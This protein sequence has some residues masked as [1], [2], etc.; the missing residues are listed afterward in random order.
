MAE[1]GNDGKETTADVLVDRLLDWRVSV[2]FGLPGDGINGIMEALRKRRERIRFVQVRHEEAA[3][4]MASGYAKFTGELGVCLAT[5]GPGAIHLLNGLYDAKL[6]GAPVL[7]LT[8]QIYHDLLGTR[9]QQEVDLLRLFDDVALYNHEITGP[10]HV[11]SLVDSACRS[12]LSGRGVAHLTCS[13]DI[14]EHEVK[15]ARK[16]KQ[17]VPGHTSP[18]WTPP[19]AVPCPGDLETAAQVL[20]GAK[21]TVILAGQGALRA[22]EEVLEAARILKAPVVKPL[23]GKAVIPDDSPYATGGIGL[24]GTLPSELAMEECDSLLIVGSTFPYLEFYPKPGQ[25]RAVQIDRD[26]ARIGLR[27]PISAPLAGDS[28]ATLSALLPLLEERD[29]D[30]FLRESQERMREWRELMRDRSSRTDE[31]LKPQVVARELGE[32]LEDDALIAADTGTVTTWVA[33]H[34][35]IRGTQ[36]FA[37]S[38][39]LASMAPGLPYAIAAQIAYP[40]R[41][42]VA[43]VGDGGFTMLMGELAT[44]VKYRLPITIVVIKNNTFGMIKWEQMVFLGNPEYGCELHP[45]DFVKFAEACG[46]IGVRCDKAGNV[47]TTLATALAASRAEG[48]PA[49][50]EAVVDPFEPPHPARLKMEQAIHMAKALARGEPNRTRIALTLFRDK[51]HDLF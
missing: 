37:A 34:V 4:F 13:V 32:L 39:N 36:Q 50:V 26:P 41:R 45:I 8:G 2:V 15:D 1:G 11:E 31:P 28:K 18:V 23:L 3:A 43:F 17:N 10:E 22:R 12:A 44:A 49:V 33:R 40:Q 19:I 5:S 46:A 42:V 21:K 7:A 27:Y 14:Q 9:Y 29:D 20:N 30:G 38:G 25:A 35:D 24:L 51:I 47:R 48:R 6:D 16:S